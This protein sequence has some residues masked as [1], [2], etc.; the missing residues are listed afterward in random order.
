MRRRRIVLQPIDRLPGGAD[1]LENPAVEPVKFP[2]GSVKTDTAAFEN[3]DAGGQIAALK[4]EGIRHIGS[5]VGP[6]RRS[7]LSG[8]LIA[9]KVQAGRSRAES[10]T[11]EHGR[12][13]HEGLQIARLGPRELP[14]G[15]LAFGVAAQAARQNP[16]EP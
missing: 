13:G 3:N 4:D 1:I 7:A 11:T 15:A 2:L 9:C 6:H 14:R 8:L 16:A 10:A 12:M 5:P